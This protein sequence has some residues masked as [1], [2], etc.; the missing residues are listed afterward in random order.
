MKKHSLLA[1]SVVSL[2]ALVGCGGNNGPK[3]SNTQKTLESMY[4]FLY[5]DEFS[6][7]YSKDEYK[8]VN[9]FG[10]YYTWDFENNDDECY[11]KYPGSEDSFICVMP[12]IPLKRVSGGWEIQWESYL[13]TTVST[14]TVQKYT[15]NV[16][17]NT[18]CDEESPISFWYMSYYDVLVEDDDDEPILMSFE[19]VN[20]YEVADISVYVEGYTYIYEYQD[21]SG[22]DQAI[23]I[24]EATF[25]NVPK[26][27]QFTA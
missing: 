22:A 15:Q 6:V 14:E 12:I 18:F 7:S 3:K 21:E 8:Y 13:G 19:L 26:D 1:L 24:C 16:M 9:E 4:S 5:E 25:Y 10:N 17:I 23:T 2:V 27:V 20:G 11:Y